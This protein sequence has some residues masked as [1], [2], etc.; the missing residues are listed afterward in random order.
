VRSDLLALTAEAVA[1]L[2]NMGLVKRAQ[3]E[4]AAGQGPQLAED[5]AGIVTGTFPDGVVARLLPGKPLKEGPCTCGALGGCRHRVAVA[6]AYPTW[7]Q[8]AAPAAPADPWWPA[9]VDDEALSRSVRRKQVELAGSAR[10]RGCDVEVG[11]GEP[12]VARLPT[13]TV[14]F[15]VPGDLAYARC[16]CAAGGGCE[17]VALAVWAFR[18]ARG[19]GPG[20][21]HLGGATVEATDP[22]A[23][24]HALTRQVLLEGASNLTPAFQARLAAVRRRLET[25]RMV[26]LT[27][28]L[29]D[30]EEMLAAYQERSTRHS[31]QRLAQLLAEM[32]ARSRAAHGAGAMPAR[33]VL[34]VGEPPDTPLGHVRLVSLGCRLE[35]DERRREAEVFL[36]DPEAG[37][38]L[39][40]RK[41]WTFADDEAPQDGPTLGGRSVMASVRLRELAHGQLVS[42]SVHRLA[43]RALR[44]STARR[45]TA[46]V[47]PQDDSWSGLP[48]GVMV[49]DLDAWAASRRDRAPSLLRPRVLAADVHVVALGAVRDVA[50]AAGRQTLY[51]RLEDASGRPLLLARAHR[52]VAPHALEALQAALGAGPRFVSGFLRATAR[53][54]EM[55]PLAVCGA[56]LV[57]PDLAPAGRLDL[58]LVEAPAADSPLAAAVHEAWSRVE[59]MSHRGLGRTGTTWLEAARGAARQLQ[60]TGLVQTAAA[61][62]ALCDRLQDVGR[63]APAEAAVVAWETAAV[64][65]Q[66]SADALSEPMEA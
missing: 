12:P 9:G 23:E 21:V 65:L 46:S 64:R 14:Q 27:G 7:A 30:V 19:R 32:A 43:N 40:M 22:V 49:H 17:H 5:E 10:D 56:S 29:D 36:A 44:V 53:G 38:V 47:T 6:L 2:T 60:A 41:R 33:A 34:G 50:Y 24:A 66:L 18:E 11:P 58:P 52:A 26:W 1:A 28:V 4:L 16:D 57:V 13:A 8:A 15:L 37:V 63:G 31:S 59:E 39:V 20:T 25:A 45:G 55:D 42:T 35:A 54:F 3:K 51:A 48:V 62:E 61:M